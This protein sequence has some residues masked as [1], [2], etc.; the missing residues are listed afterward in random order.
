MILNMVC[1]ISFFQSFFGGVTIPA[2]FDAPKA[3]DVGVF[4]GTAHKV[5]SGTVTILDTRTIYIRD[6]VYDGNG[7]G[8]VYSK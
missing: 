6:L 7:P 8:T 3:R 5:A 4:D 2:G 1:G